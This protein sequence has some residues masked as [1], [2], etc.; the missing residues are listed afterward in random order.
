MLPS[1]LKEFYALFPNIKVSLQVDNDPQLT[2]RVEEG[3]LDLVLAGP[4]ESENIHLER[5]TQDDMNY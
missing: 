1:I 2:R 3:E 5:Y 4:M